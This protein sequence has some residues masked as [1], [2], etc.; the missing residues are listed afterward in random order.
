[1]TGEWHARAC[2]RARSMQAAEPGAVCAGRPAVRMRLRGGLA[3]LSATDAA[4]QSATHGRQSTTDGHAPLCVQDRGMHGD[5][6]MAMSAGAE[7]SGADVQESGGAGGQAPTRAPDGRFWQMHNASSKRP[8]SLRGE[9]V[10]LEHLTR[11]QLYR[12][13]ARIERKVA[14]LEARSQKLKEMTGIIEDTLDEEGASTG[15]GAGAVGVAGTAETSA[16]GRREGSGDGGGEGEIDA[17][18]WLRGARSKV[19]ALM[20]QRARIE[21]LIL[22]L[23]EEV[24]RGRLRLALLRDCVMVIH[25]WGLSLFITPSLSLFIARIAPRLLF[26]VYLYLGPRV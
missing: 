7:D 13:V 14:V 6:V 22:G 1:M 21:E 24:R 4:G 17:K 8:S 2:T 10:K 5:E 26:M 15:K 25:V 12:R 20:Q 19:R 9:K 18:R 23:E 16:P 11:A 3:T